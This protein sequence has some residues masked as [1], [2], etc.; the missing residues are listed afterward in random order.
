MRKRRGHAA[1]SCGSQ[2]IRGPHSTWSLLSLFVAFVCSARP[3]LKPPPQTKK[4]KNK[5]KKE[6]RGN[7][8]L[9]R[10]PTALARGRASSLTASG[11]RVREL[12]PQRQRGGDLPRLE[13]DPR[14]G[15]CNVKELV[16]LGSDVLGG[17]S[18]QKQSTWVRLCWWFPFCPQKKESRLKQ[19]TDPP[20]GK[21][22]QAALAPEGRLRLL[23]EAAGSQRQAD[24]L[25]T[26]WHEP[27]DSELVVAGHSPPPPKKRRNNRSFQASGKGRC[28]TYE[29]R[30]HLPLRQANLM[31]GSLWTAGGLRLT[32]LAQLLLP[33]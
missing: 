9:C 4:K 31:T 28:P 18:S 22:L 14:Q 2:R 25:R 21:R 29:I 26:S 1:G 27:T 17:E 6:T 19:M 12:A 13:S 33:P 30:R 7:T 16:L 24:G 8:A 15:R 32:R 5:T 10:P 23:A 20:P 11:V 3:A